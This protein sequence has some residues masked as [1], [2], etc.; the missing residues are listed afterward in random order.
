MT[1]H[2]KTQEEQRHMPFMQQP[3]RHVPYGIVP[4]GDDRAKPTGHGLI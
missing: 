3:T 2:L 1:L 4:H